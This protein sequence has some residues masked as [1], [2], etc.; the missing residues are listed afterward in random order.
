LKV[1]NRKMAA[2]L[3]SELHAPQKVEQ[4]CVTTEQ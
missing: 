2:L 1:L 4:I 3:N